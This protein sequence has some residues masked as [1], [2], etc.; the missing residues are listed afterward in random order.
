[1]KRLICIFT[2]ISIIYFMNPI[3]AM[4]QI[5]SSRIE[6]FSSLNSEDQKALYESLVDSEKEAV[7]RRLK[8]NMLS[9]AFG[10]M[11]L[12]S[13]RIISAIFL[14]PMLLPNPREPV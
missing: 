12:V 13:Q 11:D 8:P 10:T 1:M 3:S 7:F 14:S 2:M 4:S 9:L 6:E 5:N